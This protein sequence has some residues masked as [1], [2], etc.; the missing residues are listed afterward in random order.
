M[1]L[2]DE[3]RVGWVDDGWLVKRIDNFK[4]SLVLVKLKKKK[5]QCFPQ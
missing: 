1:M 5:T 2:R 3:W 4:I